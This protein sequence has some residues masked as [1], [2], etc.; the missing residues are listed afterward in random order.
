MKWW[1]KSPPRVRQRARH[2]KP[3]LEQGQIGGETQPTSYHTAGWPHE[4]TG[5]RAPRE[6]TVRGVRVSTEPGVQAGSSDALPL[7]RACAVRAILLACATVAACSPT[8]APIG[9]TGR[10][11]A[12]PVPPPDVVATDAWVLPVPEEAAVFTV[13][14]NAV[15][16]ARA[17]TMVRADTAIVRGE[18]SV[19]PRG[20]ALDVTI[21]SFVVRSGTG[22]VSLA[23]PA[24]ALGR[25]DQ[26]GAIAFQGA[27]LD[28]CASPAAAA[29][30]FT[31]DLWMRPPSR[32]RAG[33]VWR[34]SSNVSLC[35]DGVPL[36]LTIVRDYG[37]V[38]GDTVAQI[39]TIARRT[40]LTLTG[41][42]ALRRDTVSISGRGAGEAVIRVSSRTGWLV[43]GTGT[44]QLRLEA[45]TRT[46]VQYVD[47]QVRVSFSSATRY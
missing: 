13:E 17:D 38:A 22:T 33:D 10:E 20:A 23:Q 15:I 43:D 1:S 41:T 2:G 5:D 42:G 32:V 9:I 44:S 47:Q 39:V 6:M 29:V 28:D 36:R 35:R 34:D 40:R 11:V 45:A 12:G 8:R 19:V 21:S 46:R 3:Q 16:V 25:F 4:G 26:Y 30:E 14:S 24:R 18:V 27:A 7:L 31:R 37:V